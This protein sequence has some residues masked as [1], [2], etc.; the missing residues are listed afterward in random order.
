MTQASQKLTTPVVS[1]TTGELIIPPVEPGTLP[2]ALG[3]SYR[4]TPEQARHENMAEIR[5][6]LAWALGTFYGVPYSSK[7][8]PVSLY[9]ARCVTAIIRDHG[10]P[11]N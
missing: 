7:V 1:P 8:A 4:E 5:N 10:Y 2:G 3:R 9:V 11:K 6:K